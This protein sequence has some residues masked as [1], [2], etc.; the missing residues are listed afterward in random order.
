MNEKIWGMPSNVY[1]TIMHLSQF[2]N[3]SG[4]GIIVPIVLWLVNKNKN[5]DVDRQGR[6]ILN[7]MISFLIYGIIAVLL[8][9]FLFGI[10]WPIFPILYFVSIVFPI[11][12]AIQAY[13]GKTWKYPLSFSFL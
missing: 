5:S 6:I 11:V 1:C 8:C 13:N 10:G 4:L 9:I 3:F 2:L 12:G 7:W